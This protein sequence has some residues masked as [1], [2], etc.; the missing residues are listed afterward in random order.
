M[1]IHGAKGLEFPVVVLAGLERDVAAG[2]P[3]RRPCCG[4][5]TGYPRSAPAASAR[6]GF[7]QAG[8]R[9]Q[10]SRR[11]RAAPTALRGH[12][13]GPRPPRRC[14]CTTSERNGGPDTSLAA[15]VDEICAEHTAAVAT[16]AR[17]ERLGTGHRRHRTVRRDRT[18]TP[19]G[20]GRR[21][22]PADG[23]AAAERRQRRP[24]TAGRACRRQPVDHGH[25]G[26]RAGRRRR[27]HR[28]TGGRRPRPIPDGPVPGRRDAARRRRGSLD[29]AGPCT[30]RWPTSTWPPGATPPGGRPRRWPGSRA[31]PG[32][33]GARRRRWRRWWAPRWPARPWPAAA[34]RRHWRELFVAVP[35]G[36]GG[37]SR[38]S[39]TSS[40]R[41]TTASWSSTTRP[42]ASRTSGRWPPAPPRYRL[43]LATYAVAL[44]ASTG[45]PSA[46][47]SSCSS[48]PARRCEH[49]L[50]GDELAAAMA[51]ARRAADDLVAAP[52]GAGSAFGRSRELELLARPIPRAAPV[53]AAPRPAAGDS[54]HARAPA[55]CGPRRRPGRARASP[56]PT[57]PP[58]APG[59]GGPGA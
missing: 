39:S 2:P 37:C 17:P 29:R 54:A 52:D 26:G 5:R 24:P 14:A 49:V 1:T 42:T 41:T 21:P 30:P 22:G 7:E 53:P 16:P 55:G 32:R 19:G 31:G 35:V 20:H 18:P 27:R 33:G 46:A 28:A 10:R 23:A 57:R 44:E 9:E 3:T 4:P 11:P 59:S 56:C 50:E 51:E 8:L 25:G 58:R 40:S 36:D 13:E 43:Q 34:A 6:A 48:E 47:A 15:L 45:R 38:D 12:D